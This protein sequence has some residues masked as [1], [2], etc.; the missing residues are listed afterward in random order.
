ML[1]QHGLTI[2]TKNEFNVQAMESTI[3]LVSQS[4]SISVVGYSSES[5]LFSLDLPDDEESGNEEGRMTL[6]RGDDRT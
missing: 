6:S 4:V 2:L 5:F 3:S 1:T